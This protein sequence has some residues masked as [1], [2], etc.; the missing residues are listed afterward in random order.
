[1]FGDR[2]VLQ[3]SKGVDVL[4]PATGEVE[5]HY[6]TG[7]S[8]IPSS[9]VGDGV[10]YVP[11]NGLAAVRY[12]SAN[13]SVEETWVQ[14]GLGPGTAS[15]V[16]AGEKVYVITSAGVLNCAD[17]EDGERLWRIRLEGPFGASPVVA[18]QHLYAVNERTGLLQVV[19]LSGDE[20][21]IVGNLELGEMIQATPAIANHAIFV[22]SDGHLWKISRP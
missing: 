21:E 9:A 10:L 22:R 7:A 17:V 12:D 1:M 3:G 4:V 8:T 14:G 16:V 15:P 20:G 5:W 2:V 6:G 13:R 18:G 19:D 11:S